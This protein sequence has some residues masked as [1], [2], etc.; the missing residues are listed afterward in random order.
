MYQH[1]TETNEFSGD[2]NPH[3]IILKTWKQIDCV[4]WIHNRSVDQW[5]YINKIPKRIEKACLANCPLRSQLILLKTFTN[6]LYL[7][8]WFCIFI[9]LKCVW[10][11]VWWSSFSYIFI[12][13]VFL[14]SMNDWTYLNY[15]FSS[16]LSFIWFWFFHLINLIS[17]C[18]LSILTLFRLLIMI[19]NIWR[20]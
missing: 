14:S 15:W 2:E 1:I 13:A 6:L 5:C 19:F 18:S 12:Y 9:I 20:Q 8:F 7:L 16:Y 4:I 3:L 17:V 11:S 10:K